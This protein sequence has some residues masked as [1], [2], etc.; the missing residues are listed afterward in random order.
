MVSQW[1]WAINGSG[2]GLYLIGLA[3]LAGTSLL[4]DRTRAEYQHPAMLAS[5][6]QTVG[7]VHTDFRSREDVVAGDRGSS[8]APWIAPIRKLDDALTRQDTKAAERAW[9]EAYTVTLGRWDW[10]GPIEL[11]DA[12]LRIGEVAGSRQA[13]EARARSLYLSA[14]FR[15]RAQGSVDGVR[16]TAEAFAALGDREVAALC[17]Q[18][19]EG[20]AERQGHAKARQHESAFAGRLTAWAGRE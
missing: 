10:E 4:V 17:T 15:A 2:L 16:R 9:H 18:I 1:W 7:R 11:G 12:S 14:L 13:A 6:G 3:I 20:L 5:Y 19:A 8:H